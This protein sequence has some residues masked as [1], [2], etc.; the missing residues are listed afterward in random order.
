M[1][2]H[3]TS[4]HDNNT[5]GLNNCFE[6]ILIASRKG[7]EIQEKLEGELKQT[8]ARTIVLEKELADTSRQHKQDIANLNEHI[9]ELNKKLSAKESEHN[10]E[11][12]SVTEDCACK[13][14]RLKSVSEEREKNLKDQFHKNEE[15]HNKTIAELSSRQHKKDIANLSEHIKELNKKLSAKESEHNFEL[16]SVTEDGACKLSRLKSVSEEREKNLKDQFR[17][18]EEA[19]NKTIAELKEKVFNMEETHDE[20]LERKDKNA[21]VKVRG[22]HEKMSQMKRDHEKEIESLII[23]QRDLAVKMKKQADDMLTTESWF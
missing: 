6:T 9:K 14:S 16:L 19:H 23:N 21:K 7:K 22:I 12:L 2:L 3:D 20:E 1:S 13:L 10:F 5:N 4:N 15:A 18:N 11:L 17:K 8:R